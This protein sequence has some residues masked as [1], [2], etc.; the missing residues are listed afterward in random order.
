MLLNS[1][2]G[3]LLHRAPLPSTLHVCE[4]ADTGA[5]SGWWGEL[6]CDHGVN[7]VCSICS[8]WSMGCWRPS[9]GRGGCSWMLS[10]VLLRSAA[11][12]LMLGITA[13]R[14]DSGEVLRW[15]LALI[16]PAAW[17]VLLASGKHQ[18]PP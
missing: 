13:N 2:P 7:V 1:F 8:S 14:M 10:E 4:R 9:A 12:S 18:T 6:T 3:A 15:C 11:L 5:F 17:L 16:T